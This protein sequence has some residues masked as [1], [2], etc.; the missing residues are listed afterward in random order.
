MRIAMIGVG[1]VGLVTGACFSEFGLEVACIDKNAEKIRMLQAGKIPIFEPG[2]DD[3]VSNN[4]KA[5]RL[6]FTTD[7]AEGMRDCDAVFITVG[8]PT[9]RLSGGYADL[10]SIYSAVTEIADNIDEYI[11]VVTKSTVPVGT[12]REIEHIIRERCPDRDFDICSNPEF[13]REGTAVNDFMRPDRIVIGSDNDRSRAIMRQIYQP[14]LLNKTPFVFTKLETSE[15]I[16]YASN[17]FLATKITFINEIAD[18]CERIGADVHEVALGLG[19]DDRIGHKFL[20]PGPGYG[21]SCLPK[22]A[23]ALIKTAQHYGSPLRIIET[24]VDVNSKRKK[25]MAARIVEASGGSVAGKTIALLGLTFKSNTDDLRNSPALDIVSEL[26]KDGAIL[27]GYDP[28]G[29]EKAVKLLPE[30][31]Y[32]QNPYA[33]MEGADAV[34]II[35]D[36]NEFRLLDV[37]HMKSILKTPVMVDLRNIYDPQAIEDVGI[38]YTCIGRT[39]QSLGNVSSTFNET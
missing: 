2:L 31:K 37:F 29:M 33:A 21:G 16:K 1:Y 27:H 34:A 12:S 36:W 13:L 32:Y 17:T 20:H 28:K 38:T 26:L 39:L 6:F 30:I 18:L 19:F 8:T 25:A 11:V 14:L 9:N 7:I 24:V 35:T 5:L 22:D 23:M 15:M 10:S 3:L 4:V